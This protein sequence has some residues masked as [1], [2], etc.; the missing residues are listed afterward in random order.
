MIVALHTSF[1]IAVERLN[2]GVFVGFIL[3]NLSVIQHYW[4][5]RKERAGRA[6]L[7]NLFFPLAGALVCIYIWINLSKEA[8][9]AGFIW[10]GIGILYLAFQT[11]GFRHAAGMWKSDESK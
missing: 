4:I 1:Q 9:V 10:I 8:K 2:F 6:V 11:R 3:V 5:K 7:H